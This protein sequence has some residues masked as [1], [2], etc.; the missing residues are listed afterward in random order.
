MYQL[1][2]SHCLSEVLDE[3]KQILSKLGV[4]DLFS[5]RQLEMKTLTNEG[6]SESLASLALNAFVG[7]TK[8]SERFNSLSETELSHVL[9]ALTKLKVRYTRHLSI[10]GRKK[11]KKA[12]ED[13]IGSLSEVRAHSS[14][15]N[16]L[17][18]SVSPIGKPKYYTVN[19][20]KKRISWSTGS[21]NLNQILQGGLQIGT[22]TELTGPPSSGKTQLGLTLIG[23]LASNPFDRALILT[24]D[25][26]VSVAKRLDEILKNRN[27]HHLIK[28]KRVLIQQINTS[29][30]EELPNALE[31]SLAA[32]IID[33]EI[34]YLLLDSILLSLDRILPLNDENSYK[35]R[36]KFYRNLS[37]SLQKIARNVNAVVV[38]TTPVRA[39]KDSNIGYRSLG[40]MALEEGVNLTLQMQIMGSQIKVMCA[41]VSAICKIRKKGFADP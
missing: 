16:Q 37:N 28:E 22:V 26:P 25:N 27:S 14:R 24:T 29:E 31:T 35:K 3:L 17:V 13:S 12:I 41:D 20:M 10:V 36:A 7:L 4:I 15:I 5:A 34:R 18:D 38:I 1:I 39:D 9:N 40:G 32:T 2:N 30:I 23:G 21:N 33:F 19:D 8:K 6:C 11:L